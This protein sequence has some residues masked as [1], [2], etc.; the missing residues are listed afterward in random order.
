MKRFF[1]LFMAVWALLSI[2]Q[3]VK[4]DKVTVHFI[5]KKGWSKYDAYVFD[6]STDN[7]IST[8]HAWPGNRTDYTIK[9]VNDQN[10]V[11]W[12]IDL[13][14]CTLANARIVFNDGVSSSNNKFPSSGGFNVVNDGYYDNS[15]ITSNPSEGG[16]TGGGSGS[17]TTYPTI[18]V[19]SDYN[20]GSWSNSSNSNFNF[21]T[22][23]GKIYTCTLDNVPSG[24]EA[25]YFR[26]VKEGKEYGP[27][28]D[29][30]QDL[31]LTSSYQQTYAGASKA[32]KI[33]PTSGKT[34]YTITFNYEN[35]QI[36]YDASESGGTGGGGTT[37]DWNTVTTNRLK[38]HVY[39]QGFYLA[40]NFFSFSGNQITYD[41]AVF[42]F[43]QQKNDAT[44]ESG[45]DYEVYKVEIPASLK[46]HAQ[47]MYVDEFGNIKNI[48]GPSSAYPIDKS[49]PNTDGFIGWLDT[50]ANDC[51]PITQENANYWDFV[52]RNVSTTDYS[53]GMYNLYIAV[54]ATT[55][56]VK[57]WKIAH[58]SDK[59]VTYFISDATDA[60]AMP[61]YDAY[62][63]NVEYFS[64]R[65]YG[66]VN[67]AEDRSYY[68]ISNIVRDREDAIVNRTKGTYGT[69]VP[70][71]GETDPKSKYNPTTNKLFLMGNG[72][73]D[74]EGKDPNNSV[75]PNEKPIK[76]GADWS[77]NQIVE[78]NPN[79]SNRDRANKDEHLGFVGEVQFQ[80]G[81]RVKITSVSMVGDAIP[82]TFKVDE[83]TGKEVWDFTSKAADM[84]YDDVEQCY[85]T[86][87]VTTVGDGEKHFRFVG[88]HNKDINWYEDTDGSEPEKMARTLYTD[89]KKKGHSADTS[90]PNKVDYTQDGS[91]GSDVYHIIWNRPAGRWTVRL[92]FYTRNVA[93]EPVTDYYYTINANHDLV[94][95]D[96]EDVVYKTEGERE[97]LLR[98]GYRFFRTWSDNKA[99]KVSKDVDIFIVDNM[100]EG[101][102]SVEFS[103]KKIPDTGSAHVIPAGVGVILATKKDA[104]TIEGGGK[105]YPRPSL[106]SYNTL[107]IPMEEYTGTETTAGY[108]GNRLEPMVEAGVVP[109]YNEATDEYNYLFGFFRAQKGLNDYINY[110]AQQFV[111]GFWLSKGTGLF[112]SNSAYL[113]VASATAAKMKL[114][115]KYDQFKKDPDTGKSKYIPALLFDFANVGSTTGINEVVNQSTKLNDGKYYNL[116]GQQVEKPTAGGIYIHNGRKFVVK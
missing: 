23:N 113:P 96:F 58:D 27:N 2:S 68:V 28:S 99:W 35:N 100:T 88:N 22:T 12:T 19:K 16:S 67:F 106:T 114:G 112:Y 52:S 71:S 21:T 41:D 83:T 29:A 115:T 45:K 39:T 89:N 49:H 13:G 80:G 43:Q 111:L 4:A 46:A 59:R 33:V 86:T 6:T 10:V 30:S 77:G 5:D 70:G 51:E 97:I 50:K 11:T 103:L 14:T 24:T 109:T 8:D 104:K 18:T 95:R 17:E 66:S 107:V 85:T 116:S 60:T 108:S 1:T 98:G 84:T 47:V 31:V 32:L 61:I 26:I 48:F 57:K 56:T 74:F 53:D 20:G 37:V 110:T 64:N 94:L 38:D 72:G 87:V 102:N 93:G 91:F 78:Y 63:K 34:S 90:D 55:H 9:T 75:C 79:K 3:T 82:G 7:T 15:G 40:G 36:M 54:D 44:I 81:V 69:V 73:L 65:F 25:I 105:F 101:T 42:K 76:F 62:D 92:Y